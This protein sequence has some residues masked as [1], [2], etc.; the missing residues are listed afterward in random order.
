M[1]TAE[2]KLQEAKRLYEQGQLGQAEA[3]CREVIQSEPKNVKAHLALG[4]LLQ[5]SGNPVDAR[6]HFETVLSIH[7]SHEGARKHLAELDA[8]EE[9]LL[10]LDEEEPMLEH[11]EPAGKKAARR[12]CLPLLL[13]AL[14]GGAAV[15]APLLFL[16]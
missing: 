4:T 1:P 13:L 7:P 3:I 8:E 9:R 15:A 2:E 5:K 10:G 14:L 12:G 6:A 16:C 11:V